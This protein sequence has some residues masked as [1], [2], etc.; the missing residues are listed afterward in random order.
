M[1]R[2]SGTLVVGGGVVG[3]VCALALRRA[4]ESVTLLDPQGA[5]PPASYGNAGHIATEQT[6]PLASPAA[7]ASAFRRLFGLGGALDFRLSD[8]GAWGPWAARFVAASTP[9]GAARGQQA[10]SALLR[11]ALPAWRRL[12]ESL[13]RPDLLV[14]RGHLVVWESAATARAGRAAWE[15]ADIGQARLT[16]LAEPTQARLQRLIQPA[17]AGGVAFQN[18][19]QVSNP[20]L[21][22]RLLDEA[23]EAAGGQRRIGQARRLSVVDGRVAVELSDGQR[24]APERVLVTGGVGSG[25]LMRGLGH[26][27]PIIAERGYHLEGGA[28]HWDDL[29]PV[30]FEDRSMILTRFG[31]R[32]RAASFVEFGREASPPDPRKWARLRRHLSELDVRLEGPVAEWM[33]ARPTLPDYLPAIGASRRADNLYYAFGHQHLGLTLAATTGEWVAAL[34]GG[35]A[36]GIDLAPFDLARFE[37]G[38]KTRSNP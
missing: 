8:I 10:L 27:A 29:P 6:A 7:L 1:D 19:G 24:L 32:L 12:A 4:G 14:E 23:F 35:A 18:T 11:D 15:A 31:D 28:D 25:A 36:A 5:S 17:I 30:V 9:D 16:S 38:Y 21:M 20:A 2:K 26:A 13:G 33:G 37:R 34:M 22:L 3:K